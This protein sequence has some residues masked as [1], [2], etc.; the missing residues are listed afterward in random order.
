MQAV[1]TPVDRGLKLYPIL[2]TPKLPLHL[3][4][5]DGFFQPAENMVPPIVPENGFA[6]NEA[7]WHFVSQSF[8]CSGLF[9]GAREIRV[10]PSPEVA[11]S[12]SAVV[13][14]HSESEWITREASSVERD[15]SGEDSVRVRRA[16]ETN[17]TLAAECEIERGAIAKVPG[18]LVPADIQSAPARIF[19]N[20][21]ITN[22]EVKWSLASA[23]Q[24]ELIQRKSL[25]KALRRSACREPRCPHLNRLSLWV[26]LTA[27]S[28]RIHQQ[29]TKP[30][31][32]TT[33]RQSQAQ[34]PDFITAAD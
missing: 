20:R 4:V 33:I 17:P 9:A 15:S 32:A 14:L 2:R 12:I 22:S 19:F 30:P 8:Q 1:P 18:D 29:I 16:G 6:K 34:K 5:I 21:V 26:R 7:E 25:Y 28:S 3:L 10:S 31:R 27:S 23:A 11:M 13:T 24:V